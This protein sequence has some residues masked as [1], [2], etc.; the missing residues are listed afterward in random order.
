[1]ANHHISYSQNIHVLQI[2]TTQSRVVAACSCL[3][4][5]SKIQVLFHPL[6]QS[7]KGLTV[8]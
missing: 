1:M 7:G 2:L 3:K 8:A 4:L 5:H 6:P